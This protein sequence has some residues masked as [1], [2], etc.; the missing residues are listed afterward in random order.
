MLSELS[1]AY[2]YFARIFRNLR[3]QKRYEALK[4]REQE[5]WS[6][7]I[8]VNF[9]PEVQSDQI[10]DWDE[11]HQKKIFFFFFEEMIFSQSFFY[12]FYS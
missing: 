1:G 7:L 8:K 4:G 11:T 9:I 5:P 10:S 3:K 12:F 2:I 6:Q